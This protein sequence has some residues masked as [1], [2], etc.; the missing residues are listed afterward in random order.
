[1]NLAAW[2]SACA[3][4][5]TEFDA[6]PNS[7]TRIAQADSTR[8]WIWVYTKSGNDVQIKVTSATQSFGAPIGTFTLNGIK[9]TWVND[10]PIVNQEVYALSPTGTGA[11]IVQTMSL[12][13]DPCDPNNNIPTNPYP[14]P[15]APPPPP[16]V[17]PIPVA[18]TAPSP[19]PTVAPVSLP[20]PISPIPPVN[21]APPKPIPTPQNYL[22]LIAEGELDDQ[23]ISQLTSFLGPIPNFNW[24]GT[25]Y[26]Y[27]PPVPVAA[28]SQP[29]VPNPPPPP[30][31]PQLKGLY[32]L[33]SDYYPFLT[34]FTS[35]AQ[36]TYPQATVIGKYIDPYGS[37]PDKVLAVANYMY[38]V[39]ID[40]QRRVYPVESDWL[41]L[42]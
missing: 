8:V 5:T 31:P 17:N 34:P 9:F 15:A 23:G 3:I 35:V 37:P 4:A 2:Q 40:S 16:N 26:V 7:W 22:D 6:I 42:K 1:V 32:T 36:L 21:T 20:I 13:K 25:Q 19:P 30:E 41:S 39:L 14:V 12:I 10:G 11:C 38:N 28:T 18:T 24:T 29:F 33:P 27:A